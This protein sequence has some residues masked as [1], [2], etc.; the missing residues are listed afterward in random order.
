MLFSGV[1]DY[2]RTVMKNIEIDGKVVPPHQLLLLTKTISI[3]HEK[4][5]LRNIDPV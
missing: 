4:P 2:H 5:Y 3:K 1:K